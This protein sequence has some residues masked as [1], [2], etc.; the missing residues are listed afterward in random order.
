MLH[1]GVKIYIQYFEKGKYLEKNLSSK[2]ASFV[3]IF[4]LKVKIYD[5]LITV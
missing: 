3:K 2:E 1:M 5:T 4:Y